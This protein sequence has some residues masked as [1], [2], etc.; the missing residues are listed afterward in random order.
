MKRYIPLFED[1]NEPITRIHP[2]YGEFG[3][4]EGYYKNR[5]RREEFY[6][7]KNV[8]YKDTLSYGSNMVMSYDDAAEYYNMHVECTDIK[9]N[10]GALIL[11]GDQFELILNNITDDYNVD[12]GYEGT[13]TDGDRE[14]DILVSKMSVE[15]LKENLEVAM[16]V[17]DI[18]NDVWLDTRFRGVGN[19]GN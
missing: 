13:I 17:Y 7:N 11:I 12:G 6:K 10:N 19:K 1:F 4:N 16:R 5:Y 14:F 15:K 3:S 9:K 8:P 2:N 18:V